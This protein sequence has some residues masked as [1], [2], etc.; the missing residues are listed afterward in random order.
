MK[1]L[2]PLKGVAAGAKLVAA[3]NLTHKLHNKERNEIGRVAK[4]FNGMTDHLCKIVQLVKQ[5][6][7]MVKTAAE[8]VAAASEQSRTGSIQVAQA[9][10]TMAEQIDI[11]GK[12]TQKMAD[13]LQELV[14]ITAMVAKSIDETAVSADT[15]LASA[16]AGQKIIEETVAEM[17]TIKALVNKSAGTIRTLEGSTKEIEQITSMI[18]AIADQTNLLA[19]NAAIEAARAGEA[20]RGFAVVADEV[21]KLAEQSTE[22]TK[23]INAIIRQTATHSLEAAAAMEEASHCKPVIDNATNGYTQQLLFGFKTHIGYGI[24]SNLLGGNSLGIFLIVFMDNLCNLATAHL[25]IVWYYSVWNLIKGIFLNL[26]SG[27]PGIQIKRG[28]VNNC[29]FICTG[30][31]RI[32][33]VISH[34]HYLLIHQIKQI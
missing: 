7:L 3:G 30:I 4:A 21:R 25:Y 17:E 11:Q 32:I 31:V 23:K 6:S 8:Q 19:L 20:G 18:H 13:G 15:C 12:N 10:G 29:P 26:P 14:E 24:L 9:V 1:A 33:N 28:S 27:F 2:T 5:S 34:W 22:A 16:G